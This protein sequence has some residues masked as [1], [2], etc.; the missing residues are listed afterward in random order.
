M[1]LEKLM[2][3]QLIFNGRNIYDL[4]EMKDSWLTYFSKERA[5]INVPSKKTP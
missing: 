1:V 5:V 2:N 4:E 3:N